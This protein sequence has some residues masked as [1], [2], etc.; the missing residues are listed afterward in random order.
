M[1]TNETQAT[2]TMDMDSFA[3]LF[4]ATSAA[5]EVKE[6]EIVQGTVLR[7][8]KETVVVDIGFKS[9][10]VIP[11][12]EFTGANGEVTGLMIDADTYQRLG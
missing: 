10:G 11:L 9:E 4:E 3:A 6:G 5:S 12:S 2:G 1:T 7:V 8:S